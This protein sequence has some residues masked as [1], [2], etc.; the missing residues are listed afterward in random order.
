MPLR[1]VASIV[2]V[3]L[4]AACGGGGGDQAPSPSSAS[5]SRTFTPL[6]TRSDKTVAERCAIE[7]PGDIVTFPGPA[8]GTELTGAVY[9]EGPRAAVFLHQTG[10]AGFCGWVPYAVWAARNGVRAILVDVCGYGRATC[11]PEVADDPVA[12]LTI[13]VQWARDNGATSVTVV[14]AS[15]GG[16]LAL[17]A[18]QA[19]GADAVV[20]ISGPITWMGV[21]DAP[22]AAKATTVPLLAI[23]STQDTE[24][25]ASQLN[26]AITGSPSAT[27]RFVQLPGSTHGWAILSGGV[28]V[29]GRPTASG[30]LVRD[31]IVGKRTTG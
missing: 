26:E 2:A 6:P 12:M 17:G 24:P 20:D 28:T 10:R 30:Q 4:I 29:G 16:S 27:K 31:W 23:T 21:P 19:A 5:P 15:M 9:G 25:N 8:A 14:G 3:L 11:T 1:R 7:A 13:P 22:E 18:G